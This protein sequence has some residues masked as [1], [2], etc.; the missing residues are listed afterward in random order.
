MWGT[1]DN[2]TVFVLA[3]SLTDAAPYGLTLLGRVQNH[4]SVP[5]T[6]LVYCVYDEASLN[7]DSNLSSELHFF[8]RESGE[9]LKGNQLS[10]TQFLPTFYAAHTVL[11]FVDTVKTVSIESTIATLED[12]QNYFAVGAGSLQLLSRSDKKPCSNLKN[13]EINV[14]SRLVSSYVPVSL[15]VNKSVS[16]T[17]KP[18]DEEDDEVVLCPVITVQ[19][20]KKV[21]TVGIDAFVYVPSTQPIERAINSL[22]HE[23]R[24]QL[25]ASVKL[26]EDSTLN[27]TGTFHF[28]VS[29]NEALI[30]LSYPLDSTQSNEDY[31]VDLRKKYHQILDLPLDRA[32][33]RIQNAQKFNPIEI[34]G[35]LSSVH[36]G[37]DSG[38]GNRI[39]LVSGTYDYHHY[40]QDKFNDDGWGCAY[41]SLQTI[42]SWYIHQGYT[43]KPVL[44]HRD[45]QKTIYA[46]GQRTTSFIGSK[47]WIGSLEIQTILRAYNNISSKI[48]HISKGSEILEHTDALFEH[49]AT[50]GTPIMIGGGLLA[51]T[52]LGIMRNESTGTTKYLILDPHYTGKEDLKT[53][54]GKGW[55][56]WKNVEVIFKD[57]NFY[58][59]CLPQL[60][61]TT[62]AI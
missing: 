59:L 36:L 20:N 58:N 35:R 37:L 18:E 44:G 24:R 60:P 53:I 29:W 51:F 17:Q 28:E 23:I 47:E 4:K 34:G 11:R 14:S 48:L 30:S 54:Q 46:S 19:K 8:V 3:L 39:A 52:M 43:D 15:L 10:P 42:Q 31:L 25:E 62:S 16:R 13:F 27:T 61:L 56:G 1:V 55:C 6:G 32:L 12:E 26:L 57:V 38:T 45:I 9:E 40:M 21:K 33:I 2:T 49:F 7:S 41:R 22:I 5:D 50:Q